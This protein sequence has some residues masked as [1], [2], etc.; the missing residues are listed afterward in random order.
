MS[1][2]A[3]ARGW[4]GCRGHPLTNGRFGSLVCT[5][6]T[7]LVARRD[8]GADVHNP[9]GNAGGGEVIRS[10]RATFSTLADPQPRVRPPRPRTHGQLLPRALPSIRP[11]R[12][13]PLSR[14]RVRSPEAPRA[15]PQIVTPPARGVF[16][17][18]PASACDL[19]LVSHA[20]TVGPL[21]GARRS[22]GLP[23]SSEKNT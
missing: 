10:S 22:R 16:D 15:P 18:N 2:F 4:S 20:S 14:L 9:L 8:L 23:S 1:G 3:R 17:L 13:V 12:G 7:I 6:T 21:G 19:A 11:R 5:R